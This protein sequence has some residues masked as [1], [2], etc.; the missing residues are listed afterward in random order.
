M[1]RT[2]MVTLDGSPLADHAVDPAAALAAHHGA[3]LLLVSVHQPHEP[4]EELD[5]AQRAAM[6]AY[7][8]QHRVAV[9]AR[10][11]VDVDSAVIDLEGEVADALAAFGQGREADLI[12]MTTHGRGTAGRAWFGSVADHLIRV[13]ESPILLVRHSTPESRTGFRR[14]L[15]PLDGTT[16]AELALGDAV[17]VAQADAEMILLRVVVPLITFAPDPAGGVMLAGGALEDHRRDAERYVQD[18]AARMESHG[19]RARGIAVIDTSPAA[20]IL[21]SIDEQRPDLVVL[22]GTRRSGADRLLLGSVMDKV[23]RQAPVPVLIRRSES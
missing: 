18:L 9:E 20:A 10:W 5:R 16:R 23:I 21:E 11:R 6:A 7:L 13:A 2:I 22:A 3:K 17:M 4:T 19:H 14:I 8:D 1:L 12:V 15:V